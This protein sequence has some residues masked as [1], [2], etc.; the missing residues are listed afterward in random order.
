ME[1]VRE[2]AWGAEAGTAVARE[3]DAILRTLASAAPGVHEFEHEIDLRQRAMRAADVVAV[4]RRVRERAPGAQCMSDAVAYSCDLS[5]GI[6]EL[7]T[8]LVERTPPAAR[9]SDDETAVRDA[10]LLAVPPSAV[11]A[12]PAG[13]P[14]PAVRLS[15]FVLLLCAFLSLVVA[16]ALCAIFVCVEN[17]TDLSRPFRPPPLLYACCVLAS[18]GG[19]YLMFLRAAQSSANALRRLV[20][21][22]FGNPALVAWAR[23]TLRDA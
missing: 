1:T 21:D 14:R 3:A 12:H 8:I 22:D 2:V 17:K 4:M 5:G 10:R 15:A 9:R 16:T 19:F 7:C 6:P 11:F 23:I 18:F 13:T 20:D